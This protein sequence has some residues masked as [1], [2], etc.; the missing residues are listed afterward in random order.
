S[1]TARVATRAAPALYERKY[2]VVPPKSR[3]VR[4][5][6]RRTRARL[7]GHGSLATLL[8]VGSPIGFRS[9]HSSSGLGHRPLKAEITGSNPVCAT[10]TARGTHAEQGVGFALPLT[11]T[12]PGLWS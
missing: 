11:T 5:S 9:A 6:G 2:S 12:R 3:G 7:T 8:F 1:A 4:A 10:T